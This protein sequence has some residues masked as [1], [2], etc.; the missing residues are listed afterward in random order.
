MHTAGGWV[1]TPV[2][3]PSQICGAF[4]DPGELG[5]TVATPQQEKHLGTAGAW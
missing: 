1:F 4:G 2:A 3:P 5:K